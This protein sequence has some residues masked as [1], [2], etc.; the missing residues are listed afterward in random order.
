MTIRYANEIIVTDLAR[1]ITNEMAELNALLTNG[2][3]AD[4]GQKAGS[5]RHNLLGLMNRLD[6]LKTERA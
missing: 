2:A 3:L 6:D 5:M 1:R 4:A